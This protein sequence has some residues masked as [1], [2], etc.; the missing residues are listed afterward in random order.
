[1][2]K[3]TELI[4]NYHASKVLFPQHVDLS[5]R[6][7]IDINTSLNSLV[8]AF[9]I[10]TAV[11]KQLD[12]LGEWIGRSRRV[13]T[14][15]SGIYFAFDT[16]NLGFDQGI[17]Q[18]PYDSDDGLLDL[19]DDIYR[20]VLKIK[21]GINSWNGQNDTLP[22]IINSA[23]E[24]SGIR[25][26]I[27]DNQDM[28]ISLWILG[29]PNVAMSE[30]ERMIFDSAINKG[31]FIKI[32]D[33]YTPSRYA[34]NPIDSINSELWWAINSGYFNIKSAGVR[35]REIETAKDGYTFFGFDI[36]TDY[37]QGFDSGSWGERFN[38]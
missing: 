31:P 29:D 28:S 35:V 37:V 21:I 17:W 1:M 30:L 24:G 27:V 34:D 16:I 36:E 26:A 38:V 19:S 8:L 18:G 20:L 10:D 22:E 4:S 15:L 7:L 12:I 11:G 32:P 25:I 5:T 14:P 3:Y 23:I 6:P 33:N 2:S 13:N 9:D